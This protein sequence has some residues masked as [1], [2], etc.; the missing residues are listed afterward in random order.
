M[1]L[2]TIIAIVGIVLGVGLLLYVSVRVVRAAGARRAA[3]LQ[4]ARDHRLEADANIAKAKEIGP[5]R[6]MHEQ[7]AERHTAE[8][9]RHVEQAEEHAAIADELRRRTEVA[10][11][12][13][14]RHD[15]KAAE[16]EKQVS[17]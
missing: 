8:A 11:R 4:T 14:A 5:E 12:A 9:E 6:D 10:G 7:E 17:P 16:A 2:T 1:E 3:L 15:E 13:A